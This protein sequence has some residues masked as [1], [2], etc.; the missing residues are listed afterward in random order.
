M[1][2]TE[3]L[4][5]IVENGRLKIKLRKIGQERWRGLCPWH[6][7]TRPSFD[8]FKGNDGAGHCFCHSCRKSCSARWWLQEVEGKS[9]RETGTGVRP[10]PEIERLREER[11]RAVEML[12]EFRD[13]NPD[14]PIPDEFLL[15]HHDWLTT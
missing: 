12:H 11:Q 9:Y 10:D 5:A 4:A 13:R 14:C 6:P 2:T 1:I 8:V 15:A 3:K 7:D